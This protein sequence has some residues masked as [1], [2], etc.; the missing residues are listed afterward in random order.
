MND[1]V[2]GHL[3][4]PALVRLAARLG[5]V[6]GL[7]EAEREALHAAAE[8]ALH[9][10]VRRLVGRVLLLELHAARLTGRLTGADPAARWAEWRALT[11]TP[12]FWTSLG[13]HYPTLLPRL[14][15]VIGNR[16]AAAL[17][18]AH[19]FATDRAALGA[20]LGGGGTGL[21]EVEFAAG[22]SHRGGQTVVILGCE[23][24]RV[25]YKPRPVSVDRALARFLER[26]LHD[27]PAEARIR[28]PEVVARGT[29]GWAG[30]VGHRHCDGDAELRA[31]HRGLGHWLAVMLLLG[32]S[33]L[34]AENL[35]A[36]GPVP[37]VVDCETLFTPP[38][39]AVELGCGDATDRAA[40][41][42]GGSVLG[43]G[44]LPDRG[45]A[46]GWRG[47]DPSGIGSLPGQQPA[48]ELQVVL[49]AGTDRARMG[50]ARVEVPVERNLPSPE[51]VLGAYWDRVVAGFTELTE[52]LRGL[53]EAGELEPALAG[54]A[55]V[56]VRVV[57]R[58]TESYAELGRMLWHP[59]S[60]HDEPAARARAE[61]VL[62]RQAANAP[63]RP[64]DPAVIAAEV[65]DL[66]VADV[67]VYS[68]TPRRGLL[69]GPRGTTWGAADDLFAG[70]LRRWR[71]ADV[72]VERQVIRSAVVGAYLNDG[73]LRGARSLV[74]R[75]VR[76]T[77]LDR[78][79][80]AAAAGIVRV[81]AASA[82]RGNDGSATWIGPVL[83]PAGWAV[84]PLGPDMYGGTAGV[85]VLLAAYRHEVAHGRA[86]PVPEADGLL[87]AVLRTLR[88]TGD[89][90]LP[91][92]AFEVA[93]GYLGIGSWIWAWLLLGRLGAVEPAE[94]VSRASAALTSLPAALPADGPAGLPADGPSGLP[95]G[96]AGLPDGP[97]GLL[98]G[99]AGAVV[100]LLRLDEHV[101]GGHAGA[102]A[103]AAEIGSRLVAT[104]QVRD[105]IVR[106]TEP[107]PS[108]ASAGEPAHGAAADP[109]YGP[110][111]GPAH[112]AA[113]LAHG[114]A[115]IGWALSRLAA[116]TGNAEAAALAAAV[117][118]RDELPAGL[119]HPT[120]GAATWA[121]GA[122]G[123]GVVAA[124]E[125]RR[126]ARDDPASAARWRAVLGR[127]AA[128]C[129]A[130]GFGRSH[131]LAHGDLGAWEVL[132]LAADAGAIG[133]DRE[134][135][136][137]RML[138]GIEEFG[139]CS[140][141]AGNA[142]VPGLLPGLGGVAYQLL[143]M[144][145]GCPLPSVLL[146]DP[147]A[148]DLTAPARPPAA[149]LPAAGL[150]QGAGG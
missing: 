118:G 4:E 93:G 32:G 29:Y 145:P 47:I 10:T 134:R 55:D 30:H 20:L 102:V 119:D 57:P 35:V 116:A 2:P 68:T 16:C 84:L 79:R 78:R 108:V 19:R 12:A 58:S 135:L 3:L 132:T 65:A 106:W 96:S 100:P 43:T 1:T 129:R 13:G 7:A 18:L 110:A 70:A 23:G 34:H 66:L 140:G 99:P 83:D 48:A 77:D 24:G 25:V 54:F 8:A 89:A 104:A 85:A 14:R 82:V 148:G 92:G 127:A 75:R 53:D 49:D 74:P 112:G 61:A 128:V 27:E 103:L 31:F 146:P 138:S 113:G 111:G 123:I 21:A 73:W 5:A 139:P 95:D 94:A 38:P 22:D 60:L 6:P 50:R 115:G 69:T 109:A 150:R 117:S 114:A 71:A 97:A 52:R 125:L 144:H 33:D 63:G 136:D 149:G 126:V 62:A 51:P 98:D 87:R 131:T 11:A 45:V 142:L 41:L 56:P 120:V 76:T 59:A 44:L 107:D 67:P 122:G 64:D 39:P 72:E 124:D 101:P 147:G 121:Y 42:L 90:L 81:L 40:A 26:V 17:T 88:A 130:D 36:A 143:R 105:G 37:V 9:D 137:G 141:F 15:R 28:V 133:V 91:A 46:L 80:R 86:D